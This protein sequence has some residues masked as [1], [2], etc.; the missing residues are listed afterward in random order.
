M[1]GA[2]IARKSI[3]AGLEALNRRDVSSFMKAWAEDS[4]WMYPGGLSVSGRFEGKKAVREWFENLMRQFPQLKFTVHDVSVSNVFDLAGNNVAAAHWD[5]ALTNKDGHHL[6]YCGVTTL[7]I[8]KG[9]VTQG[10]D[11]LF[12]VDE[13]VRHG[14]GE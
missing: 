13:F 4:V 2:I 9:K 6:E 3:R 11:Y 12:A 7:A 1:I 10:C 14:W 5:V 8:R